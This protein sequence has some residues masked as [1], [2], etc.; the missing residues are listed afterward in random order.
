ME[1]LPIE[2][3]HHIITY[4]SKYDKI[5]IYF[6]SKEFRSLI[7]VN[8]LPKKF[9]INICMFLMQYPNTTLYEWLDNMGFEI[10]SGYYCECDS[11]P[12]YRCAVALE[13]LVKYK[14]ID[15]PCLYEVMK[16]KSHELIKKYY[17][18]ISD[19]T[20][21]AKYM[22]PFDIWSYKW[23]EPFILEHSSKHKFFTCNIVDSIVRNG[24]IDLFMYVFRNCNY[25]RYDNTHDIYKKI[26]SSNNI[27]LY[28]EIKNK[29]KFNVCA[30]I[31]AG[32]LGRWDF[33]NEM[34]CDG[35][36]GCGVY[37]RFGNVE[38]L[39]VALKKGYVLSES[40]VGIALCNNNLDV[41]DF[42][43]QVFGG[44]ITATYNLLLKHK[45]DN[46]EPYEWLKNKGVHIVQNSEFYS[47]INRASECI[48]KFFH[49]HFGVQI[50][51]QMSEDWIT[52]NVNVTDKNHTQHVYV[53]AIENEQLNII[54][55]ALRR[56]VPYNKNVI[57]RTLLKCKNKKIFSWV[58]H[59]M[60][61]IGELSYTNLVV[62]KL[63]ASIHKK[64]L[65]N[66]FTQTAVLDIY[67]NVIATFN[68]FCKD[69]LQWE[70]IHFIYSSENG[71]CYTKIIERVQNFGIK[72]NYIEVS[73]NGTRTSNVTLI[74]CV[75]GYNMTDWIADAVYQFVKNVR[76]CKYFHINSDQV[77]IYD[78][79]LNVARTTKNNLNGNPTNFVVLNTC[80][81][82]TQYFVINH[83]TY[84]ASLDV[85]SGN[86]S[87][88][89]DVIGQVY[90]D[91]RFDP[92]DDHNM[93]IIE[94]KVF[95][96]SED[97]DGTSCV[98]EWDRSTGYLLTTYKFVEPVNYC[99]TD[100]TRVAFIGR[101]NQYMFFQITA[102]YHLEGNYSVAD[103]IEYATPGDMPIWCFNLHTRVARVLFDVVEIKQHLA[104]YDVN[105]RVVDYKENDYIITFWQGCQ[106][107]LLLKINISHT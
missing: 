56:G 18:D 20:D 25:V 4:L 83:G 50:P 54:Q 57:S 33:V 53:Y 45:V 28:Q 93:V 65:I 92:R 41:A 96:C 9:D 58:K 91:H 82:A 1:L 29:I 17:G 81:E 95:V 38:I 59:H 12:P 11:E 99:G 44:D 36:S 69:T 101:V 43:F 16:L 21:Y 63:D 22:R 89:T 40:S 64:I 60:L 86:L 47:C 77:Y 23:C 62:E 2:I 103:V 31:Y 37:E 84:V 7:D 51:T 14:Y 68:R 80:D 10:F 5:I 72:V 6:V 104:E 76:G 85:E 97:S 78:L 3:I 32:S 48:Q 88:C 39:G 26:I 98:S 19:L 90:A 102:A 15:I 8:D 70:D 55:S 34:I 105:I 71:I 73:G 61:D 79:K 27:E 66:T 107:N 24:Y 67:N 13:W 35:Y 106:S 30:I 74:P 75:F 42:C 49:N 52:I 87:M 100:C 94:D 46:V